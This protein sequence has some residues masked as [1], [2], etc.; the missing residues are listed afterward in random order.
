MYSCS[1]NI[2]GQR[3]GRWWCKQLN[4]AV[5]PSVEA[6]YK[7]AVFFDGESHHR[8]IIVDLIDGIDLDRDMTVN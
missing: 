5:I 1:I 7:S 4:A 2:I 8:I 3:R 6:V